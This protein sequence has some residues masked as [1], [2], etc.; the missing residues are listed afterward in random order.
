MIARISMVIFVAAYTLHEAAVLHMEWAC[1]PG[2][3]V[4]VVLF[5]RLGCIG[6]YGYTLYV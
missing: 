1:V 4:R 3:H 5:I 6:V 2:G